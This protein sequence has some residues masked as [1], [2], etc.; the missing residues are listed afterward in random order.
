MEKLWR[1]WP[2]ANI[3][4]FSMIPLE[5]RVLYVNC[6]SMLWN[7][8]LSHANYQATESHP[9]YVSDQMIPEQTKENTLSSPVNGDHSAGLESVLTVSDDS[10]EYPTDSFMPTVSSETMIEANQ[11][12]H[13][14]VP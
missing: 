12:N 8:Y 5:Y 10:T 14:F 11:P 4:N 1:F 13:P 2:L 7:G 3:I 9:I 6:M